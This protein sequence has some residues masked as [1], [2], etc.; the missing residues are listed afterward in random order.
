M[1]QRMERMEAA[2]ERIIDLLEHPKERLKKS[3]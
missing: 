2:L 1:E 3:S